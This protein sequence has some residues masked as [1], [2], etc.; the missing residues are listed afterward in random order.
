[1]TL[2]A[3]VWVHDVRA[4]CNL[5]T[6]CFED[7]WILMMPWLCLNHF[8]LWLLIFPLYFFRLFGTCLVVTAIYNYQDYFDKHQNIDK[9][10]GKTLKHFKFSRLLLHCVKIEINTCYEM[11]L[12]KHNYLICVA[13]NFIFECI[14]YNRL[15]KINYKYFS[16]Q[17][18]SITL[19][20]Y[21]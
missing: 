8:D 6:W 4:L 20:S 13:F 1:M 12:H 14:Y 9:V 15:V 10:T 3:A 17:L 21:I 11:H 16:L 7:Y 2:T 19:F 18:S 5:F